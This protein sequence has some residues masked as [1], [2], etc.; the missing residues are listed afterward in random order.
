VAE[1]L[2]APGAL[3]RGGTIVAATLIAASPSTKI[4]PFWASVWSGGD[5]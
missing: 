5:M 3:L 1:H 2:E 4:R